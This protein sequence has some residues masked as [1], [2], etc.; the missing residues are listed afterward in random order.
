MMRIS[1]VCVQW[2]K[3]EAF[4]QFSL[5]KLNCRNMYGNIRIHNG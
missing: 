4:Y 3:M 1:D 5:S 2:W